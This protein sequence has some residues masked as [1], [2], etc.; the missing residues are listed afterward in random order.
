ME[1]EAAAAQPAKE[2]APT[3]A[4][5]PEHEL[6]LICAV[7]AMHPTFFRIRTF[8]ADCTSL[9]TQGGRVHTERPNLFRG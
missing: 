8:A 2:L 6:G 7:Y 9:L 3:R 5:N 4:T 1:E